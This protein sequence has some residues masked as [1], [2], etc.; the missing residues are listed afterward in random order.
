MATFGIS[1]TPWCVCVCLLLPSKL[2][3]PGLVTAI[4]VYRYADFL[5][6]LVNVA[7]FQLPLSVSK[8]NKLTG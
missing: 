4:S 3:F 5:H 7:L 2:C 1:T 6:D 8:N